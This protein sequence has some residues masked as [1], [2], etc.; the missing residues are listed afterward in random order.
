MKPR[1]TK[2]SLSYWS[3]AGSWFCSLTLSTSLQAA[4]YIPASEQTVVAVLPNYLQ[5]NS[6]AIRSF[7]RVLEQ[8][9][10]S[11]EANVGLARLYI[12]LGR[13]EADPR[14]YGYAETVLQPWWTEA[15]PPPEVLL[16]RATLRQHQHDYAAA[17]QDLKQLVRLQPNSSQGWLTLAVVQWVQGD[18][19]AARKT[20]NALLTQASTWYGSL[21][22]SQV[23]SFTGDAERAYAL[24]ASLLPSFNQNSLELQQWVTTNLAEI[25]WRLGKL[26]LA[27]EHF[28]QALAI[29]RRDNY[30]LRVYS[31]FLLSEQ[32]PQ[33]VLT[34]LKDKGSDDALLLR[35]ALAS[36]QAQQ[37]KQTQAYRHQLEARYE[38]ARLRQ[39][40]LHR[41]DEAL[42]LLSFAG[43]S[44]Q[45]LALAQANWA[46]QK[47]A[48]DTTLLLRAALANQDW[49]TARKVQVWLAQTEQQDARLQALLVQIPVEQT[50]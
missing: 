14:Y 40:S 4:A 20:C 41:R 12:E 36:Q 11:L 42:Y 5:A 3:L 43:D 23:L 28:Q 33:E 26:S 10:Y 30:L 27:E 1:F 49:V 48:E 17:L 34:L 7:K 22:F 25:A 35:L 46:E 50:L 18:Y 44:K 45:A 24:Q 32:R 19:S 13:S 39:S 16:L 2:T 29:K 38:A 9:P 37:T 21:C 47:E 31:D 15:T 6:E 8:D